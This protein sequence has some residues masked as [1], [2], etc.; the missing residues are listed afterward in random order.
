LIENIFN[1]AAFGRWVKFFKKHQLLDIA[2]VKMLVL[3]ITRVFEVKKLRG[4]NICRFSSVN[5]DTILD[6]VNT[7][8]LS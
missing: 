2:M 5:P 6:V 7:C 8:Y 1:V 4:C 3:A